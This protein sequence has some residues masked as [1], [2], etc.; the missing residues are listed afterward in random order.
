LSEAP[1][2]DVRVEED[3]L[4]MP[5]ARA[6][7]AS[8]NSVFNFLTFLYPTI[9]TIVMTPIVLHYIG[10][11]GY[12]IFAVASVFVGF[13]AV[14]DFGMGPATV[15]FV[16]EHVARN[17]M[18]QASDVVRAGLLVYGFMGL[19]GCLLASVLGWFF[20][21]SLFHFPPTHIRTARFVFVV[22]GVGFFLTMLQNAFAAIPP[23]LQR[24]D[25]TSRVSIALTT[26]GT[27]ATVGALSL[28]LGLRGIIVVAA[29]QPALAV[30][31]YAV[32]GRRLLGDLP[33]L[34]LWSPSLLRRMASFSVWAFIGNV[35]GLILF[36]LDKILLAGLGTTRQVAYYVVP[37]NIAQRV[38]T[39]AATLNA[40]VLPATTSLS[41]ATDHVRINRL[42][43]SAVRFTALFVV[44]VAVA[45]LVLSHQLLQHWVGNEFAE[46][47]ALTL[48]LL[49]LTYSIIALA[50]P[51]YFV[52]LGHNRPR[53]TAAFNGTMAL[54][55]VPLVVFLIP[56][57]GNDG[58]AYA[59]LA[60]TIPVA[61]FILYVERFVLHLERSPWPGL[62]AR[63]T[64]LVGVETTC[65]V[66]IRAH[67]TSLGVVLGVL[68]ISF[69]AVP[70]VYLGVMA[71]A[72]DRAIARGLVMR[73][74][75]RG[76]H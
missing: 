40:V 62:A 16:A 36:Q 41:A 10:S 52:A 3:P 23:A 37:G 66:Y 55:N 76:S 56:K 60:S 20:L 15:R 13:L 25:I 50:A 12:G 18:K 58:A 73:A 65:L 57:Y 19:L 5:H 28:G 2:H 27:L 9:L 46:K 8:R 42:Y 74:P 59:Y 21:P 71:S 48:Q 75:G 49:L 39:A 11:D 43:A 63:L 30:A 53:I 7:R 26:F 47:S 72:E 29:L 68:C 1:P 44:T 14:L 70:L 64:P 51:A 32:Y 61:G 69:L 35:N 33:L 38:H 54:I 45:P 6:T 34:P 31:V 24:Y 22:A 4:L 17:E 67:V